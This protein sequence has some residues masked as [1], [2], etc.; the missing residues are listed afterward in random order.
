MSVHLPNDA[1]SMPAAS[2]LFPPPPFEF[3]DNQ[4]LTF[5]FRTTPAAHRRLV[6]EPLAPVPDA[7][8][9][10]Y[11]GRLCVVEPMPFCYMEAA[12]LVPVLHQGEPGLYVSHMYL[13]EALPI[14]IGREIWGYPKV[15]AMI[16]LR[17]EDNLVMGRVDLWGESL[18]R[19]RLHGNIK[20]DPSQ[21]EM[22]T[23]WYSL[24]LIPSPSAGARPE[25][26][27]LVATPLATRVRSAR[28]GHG[29]LETMRVSRDMLGD[30]PVLGIESAVFTITDFTLGA[31]KVVVDYLTQ[32]QI[33]E[34]A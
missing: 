13:D 34:P 25:V 14:V 22:P 20:I 11:V 6:P 9:A 4:I 27:E 15:P 2:A 23:T 33:A 32:E 7:V 29:E 26:A 12:L 5:Q 10:L 16:D 8:L 28:G 1:Y 3:R 17:E 31:G 19:A 21:V 30:I 18:I 24:K